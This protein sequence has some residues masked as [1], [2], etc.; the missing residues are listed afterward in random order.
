[1]SICV[2]EK[3]QG[4]GLHQTSHN[5]GVIHGGIYYEPRSLKARLCVEGARELYEFCER[6]G[7]DVERCG[8]VVV[9][10][11]NG[12][13]VRLDELERRGR[14]NG[15]PG[16]RRVDADELREL[17]PHA[18]G[19]AALHSPATGTVD[20][21]AVAGAMAEEL[22]EA[23]VD[24]H[25]GC[26]VAA[27]R[28]TA[29]ELRIFHDRGATDARFA[30]FC[31]GA[32]SD[33]MAV[34]GGAPADPVIVPFRGAYLKLREERRALVR[35]HVYP[36]PDPALPFLGVHLTRHISGNV[37]VGPSA[38]LAPARDAYTL[39]RVRPRD[40]AATVTWPGT[41]RMARRWWR[42]GCTELGYAASRSRFV[43]AAARLVP[44]LTAA[45]VQPGFAGVRAQAVSRAGKL[46]DDFAFSR[47][48]RALHVRNSP[49]PAATSALAVARV[50]V[51]DVLDER[52]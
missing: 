35:G 34:R 19:V 50:V 5:S 23:A 43:R 22:R 27:T 14:A 47:T 37:L 9:A 41:W 24:V 39:V 16:L 52:R 1:M 13:L 49:S 48:E 32:W 2:L 31:A 10:V 17:E 18:A 25:T 4:I 7:V 44:E 38:L 33:R 21:A 40:L 20:F 29:R 6:R 36:V 26:A 30:I 46:V 45:D 8:K 11:D 42:T 15:V 51:A 28:P 3:E 12:E